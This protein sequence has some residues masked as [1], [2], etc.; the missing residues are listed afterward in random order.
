MTE[1]ASWT[2]NACGGE[3][4]WSGEMYDPTLD[5]GVVVYVCEYDDCDQIGYAE[6]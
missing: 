6:I 4:V 3:L 5:A 1:A 2:C